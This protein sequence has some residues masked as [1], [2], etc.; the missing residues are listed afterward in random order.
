[1]TPEGA[2]KDAL[3]Q[4]LLAWFDAAT[5]GVHYGPPPEDEERVRNLWLG[6]IVADEDFSSL[7]GP[8]GA[9][10]D[11]SFSVEVF[12]D[13]QELDDPSPA[14]AKKCSA[15]AYELVHGLRRALRAEV[16]GGGVVVNQGG[17]IVY[18]GHIASVS[19]SPGPEP[20]VDGGWVETVAA[21]VQFTARIRS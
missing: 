8:G 11:E 16:A 19:S 5:T 3:E 1:M 18:W 12:C 15:A 13:A 9:N 20:Y 7:A 6:G 14:G 17:L 21:R 2:A 10:T 4:A